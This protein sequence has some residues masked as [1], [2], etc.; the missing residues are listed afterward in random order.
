LTEIT[1][2]VVKGVV[3]VVREIGTL[4][5]MW[6]ESWKEEIT[7][8]IKKIC[9]AFGVKHWSDIT[10]QGRRILAI[11]EPDQMREIAGTILA[12]KHLLADSEATV[13][14]EQDQVIC[15]DEAITSCN[16][17]NNLVE[18]EA[19]TTLSY[20]DEIISIHARFVDIQRCKNPADFLRYMKFVCKFVQNEFEEEKANNKKVWE[21]VRELNP[22]TKIEDFYSKCGI[23]GNP[24]TYFL[25]EVL[26]DF[27][28][29]GKK[30]FTRLKYMYDSQNATSSAQEE[31]GQEFF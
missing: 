20:D 25:Q 31:A 8:V 4:L 12:E 16:V 22:D 14:P 19:Q 13:R 6:W 29:D 2:S 5:Q 11:A 18:E 1:N 28:D 24:D 30:G 26:K 9:N 7:E 15:A 3:T 27:R 10:V 17:G 23:S 21:I